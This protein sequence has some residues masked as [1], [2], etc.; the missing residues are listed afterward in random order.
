M[1]IALAIEFNRHDEMKECDSLFN[2]SVRLIPCVKQD[3]GG[4]VKKTKRK[5]I[6]QYVI[7]DLFVPIHQ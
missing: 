2:D 5:I 4:E 6:D 1:F 7:M 3:S